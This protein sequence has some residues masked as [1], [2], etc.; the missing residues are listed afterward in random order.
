MKIV[1]NNTNKDLVNKVIEYGGK[2]VYEC[3]QCGMCAS[4]CP[5]ASG[6]AECDTEMAGAALHHTGCRVTF[7]G[8]GRCPGGTGRHLRGLFRRRDERDGSIPAGIDD[9]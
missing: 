4:G 7:G 9:Q 3:F 2:R 8:L 6:A 5:V 1:L